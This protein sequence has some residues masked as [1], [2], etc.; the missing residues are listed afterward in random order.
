LLTAGEENPDF[1]LTLG[2]YPLLVTVRG[3][4]E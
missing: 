1:S 3:A 2:T 4:L